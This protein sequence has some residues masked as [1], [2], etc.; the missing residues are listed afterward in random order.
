[1]N[2]S[3]NAIKGIAERI[4]DSVVANLHQENL[5]RSK[6]QPWA[7]SSIRRSFVAA[8]LLLIGGLSGHFGP[9]ILVPISAGEDY[10]LLL[11]GARAKGPEIEVRTREY[12]AWARQ[13]D[14]LSETELISASALS[15]QPVLLSS[16][17]GAPGVVTTDQSPVG[18][19]VIKAKSAQDALRVARSAPHLRHG[20]SIML[21]AAK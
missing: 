2:I 20:G 6:Q 7:Q 15:E 11:Y 21:A 19:F 5:I 8:S 9:Q 16:P 17:N 10:V 18:Y 4:E 3:D 14:G 1:M 13:I 12:G